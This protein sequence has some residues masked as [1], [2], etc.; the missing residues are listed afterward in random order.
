MG[1][2]ATPVTDTAS[3]P[4]PDRK[5]EEAAHLKRMTLLAAA[6]TLP[7]FVLEMGGHMIPAFHHW[8]MSTLG[9]QLSWSIQFVLTTI[10]LAWPGRRFFVTGVP[11]LLKRTP[12]MN[13][14][15]FLGATAAWGFS[16]VALF[17]PQLLPAGAQ[18]VYFEAAAM[19]VTLI[20]LGRT[21]EA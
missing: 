11:A 12:D 16:T 17:L 20:L 8:V 13:S 2:P 19:I 15:V 1:Y 9:Q 3:S 6:L 14:L 5:V 18:A 4:A 21:L 7:V 10:V